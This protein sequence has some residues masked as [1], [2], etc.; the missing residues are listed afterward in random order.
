M[1]ITTIL[2]MNDLD[3]MKCKAKTIQHVT[4]IHDRSTKL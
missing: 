1:Q 2:D 4:N 3:S